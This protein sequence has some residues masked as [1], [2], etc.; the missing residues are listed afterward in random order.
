MTMMTI[1]SGGLQT[2]NAVG[3][4]TLKVTS[5]WLSLTALTLQSIQN[6]HIVIHHNNACPHVEYCGIKSITN[7]G[8]AL[9][10]HPPYSLTKAPTVMTSIAC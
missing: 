6:N 8:W 1:N 5:I 9:L 2:K 4:S 7:K 10:P 3:S